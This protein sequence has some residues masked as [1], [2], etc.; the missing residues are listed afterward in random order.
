[1]VKIIYYGET[2]S[3]DQIPENFIDFMQLAGS[4]FLIE[5][6]DKYVFEYTHDNKNFK[7]LNLE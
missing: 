3:L 2:Q 1:M 7:I 5:D 4:L 6:V